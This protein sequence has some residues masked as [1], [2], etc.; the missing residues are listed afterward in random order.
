M[1]R[2]VSREFRSLSTQSYCDG[3]P[4]HGSHSGD[5]ICKTDTV[6]DRDSGHGSLCIGGASA[7]LV[8]ELVVWGVEEHPLSFHRSTVSLQ[9]H[10]LS[11]YLWRYRRGPPLRDVEDAKD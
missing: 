1:H 3:C 9:D 11:S 8:W 7:T 6:R 5:T 4:H 2:M 10:K